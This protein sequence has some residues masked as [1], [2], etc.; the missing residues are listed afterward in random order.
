MTDRL[1]KDIPEMMARMKARGIAIGAFY[2]R[3][4]IQGSTWRRWASGEFEPTMRLWRRACEAY[5]ELIAGPGSSERHG[6]PALSGVKRKALSSD[7]DNAY[8]EDSTIERENSR[9]VAGDA[10]GRA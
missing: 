2:A 3:A 10:E 7:T 5:E 8:H 9:G 1:P 4:G 6:K